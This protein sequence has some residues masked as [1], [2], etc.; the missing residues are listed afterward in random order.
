MK[1]TYKILLFTFLFLSHY[2]VFAQK[3]SMV[4]CFG[5]HR[6]LDFHTNPP[7]MITS[8]SSTQGGSATMCDKN[9]SLLFYCDGQK[10]YTRSHSVMQNGNGL[11]GDYKQ[12]MGAIIVPDPGS[13]SR[14]FVFCIGSVGWPSYYPHLT[15]NIVDM[16]FNGGYGQVISKNNLLVDSVVGKVTA[17]RHSNGRSIWV[18]THKW[19]T[20]EFYAFEIN[21]SGINPT[22][23]KSH[24]HYIPVKEKL[25]RLGYM[26][27]SPDGKRLTAA[28]GNC[29]LEFYM[30]NSATGI[31][32]YDF[33]YYNTSG[34]GDLAY[35]QGLE[36]SP[37][38]SKLYVSDNRGLTNSCVWQFD[39]KAG[40]SNSIKNSK[41]FIGNTPYLPGACQ[42]AIDKKIYITTQQYCL[43]VIE[44]PNK[45]G[46]LCNYKTNQFC[47]GSGNGTYCYGL[48]DYL[49]SYFFIPDF[50]ATPL[51]IGDT[52]WFEIS[53]K[54]GVDSV[55]W[56]FGDTLSA[57]SNYSSLLSPGHVFSDT[58]TFIVEVVYWHSNGK[59]DK[60]TRELLVSAKPHANFYIPDTSQC[61]FNN[62]F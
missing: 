54:S 17:V 40:D 10:I 49:T 62:F 21:L 30:F 44:N 6:G 39:L 11:K 16:T 47:L 9:G 57:A 13:S 20:D 22:P 23:V 19:K 7:T 59:S 51:C 18:V 38:I 61:L 45:K 29:G 50:T 48:P 56:C 53:N 5:Q 14:Y 12:A 2:N 36:Y 31:L 3:E 27:F 46:S 52:T 58:G 32:S 25:R 41:T 60:Y 43:C 37:D 4:W 42:I 1:H 28:W 24:G 15:Y 34:S 55:R 35:P 33:G 26:K 8:N